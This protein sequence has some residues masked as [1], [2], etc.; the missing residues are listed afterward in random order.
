[1]TDFTRFSSYF[2]RRHMD[3]RMGKKILKT[4]TLRKMVMKSFQ[5]NAASHSRE[6]VEIHAS[7]LTCQSRKEIDATQKLCLTYELL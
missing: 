2:E 4:K 3:E 1:M 5:K 6:V 7:H